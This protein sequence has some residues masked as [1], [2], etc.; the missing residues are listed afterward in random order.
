VITLLGHL[1][2]LAKHDPKWDVPVLD[3]KR[4]IRVVDYIEAHFADP[5]RMDDL[6]AIACLSTIQFSR[7]FKQTVG[8]TPHRYLT[9]RRIAQARHLLATS[10]SP[11]TEIGFLCGFASSAHFSTV[12]AQSTGASPLQFRA[13]IAA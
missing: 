9:Q 8:W 11:V 5:I 10:S 4:L 7:A 6:A 12:F 3:D 1:M 2:L 13:S